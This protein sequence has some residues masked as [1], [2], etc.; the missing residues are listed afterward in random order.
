MVGI[1][2]VLMAERVDG[3]AEQNVLEECSGVEAGD[4]EM[5]DEPSRTDCDSGQERG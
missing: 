3:L 4:S 2:G 5:V 1:V